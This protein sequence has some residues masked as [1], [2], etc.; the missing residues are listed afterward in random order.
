MSGFLKGDD[1]K[2]KR[3]VS[4]FFFLHSFI[5]LSLPSFLCSILT[6]FDCLEV[7]SEE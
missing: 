2:V 7:A 1:I 3:K 5:F 6:L 4:P